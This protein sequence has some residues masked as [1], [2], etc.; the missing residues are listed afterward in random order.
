MAGQ[1]ILALFLA[2]PI[3]L[4]TVLVICW[5]RWVKSGSAD[6]WFDKKGEEFAQ[7]PY[8]ISMRTLHSTTKLTHK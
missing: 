4:I 6:I 2:V 3:A 1:A 7:D 8:L 5:I